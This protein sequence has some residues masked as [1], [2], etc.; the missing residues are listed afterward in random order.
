M[1]VCFIARKKDFLQ[2][3]VLREMMNSYLKENDVNVKDGTDVNAIM[4]DMISI[5]LEGALD[6]EMKEKIGYSKYNY[7]HKNTDNIR[8][9]HTTKTMH[10][11]YEDIAI[12]IPKRI[13]DGSL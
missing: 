10:S 9:G 2:K 8:N 1:E 13:L 5:I 11:R 3:A 12:D 7:R 6:T 4:K